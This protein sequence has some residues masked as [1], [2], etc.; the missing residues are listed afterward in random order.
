MTTPIVAVT[1]AGG[2]LG[3]ALVARLAAEEIHVRAITRSA[4]LSI[5]GVAVVRANVLDVPSLISQFRGV[6]AVFH[7]VAHSHDLRS[8]DDT[9]MQQS[10]TLG[11]RSP[12][13]RPLSGPG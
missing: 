1:G 3:R 7:L 4:T 2:F 11:A 12:R 6:H 10:V 13:S 9:I 5:P 8:L